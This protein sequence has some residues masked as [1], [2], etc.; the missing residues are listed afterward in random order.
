MHCYEI[1]QDSQNFYCID[2]LLPGGDL[3]CL[4]EKCQQLGIPLTENYW[5][6]VFSQSMGALEYMHRHAMMHCDI[7][8]PNIMFK[9]KDYRNPVIALI[10]FGMSKWAASD[11]M[12]G[13]TPGYRPPETNETNVWF[14]RGDIFSMGVSFFQLLAD[15]V[16]DE[17]TQRPGIFTEGAMSMEQVNWFVKTRQPPWFLIQG[18]YPGVMS[19]LPQMLDKQWRNRPKAPQLLNDAWFNGAGAAADAMMPQTGFVMATFEDDDDEPAN[20]FAQQAP[21]FA[22]YAAAQAVGSAGPV[23]AAAPMRVVQG[24]PP[25]QNF[26]VVQG[27]LRTPRNMVFQ[28]S[29]SARVIRGGVM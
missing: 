22:A 3:C 11:G 2:E 15:K 12:A 24:A 25:I 26:G 23:T 10:D 13:G 18:K 21:Q 14:P 4:R 7:K 16:P 29:Q 17:K 28:G 19:W 27:S 8:E 5:Q 1:F 6:G 20:P 9:I